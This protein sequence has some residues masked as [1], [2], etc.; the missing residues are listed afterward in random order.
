MVHEEKE[1]TKTVGG[2]QETTT[3]KWSYYKLSPL[4]WMTYQEAL[5]E[6]RLIGSGLRALGVGGE[7]ETFFNI[8]GQTS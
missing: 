2:K 8:Y 7:G 5:E 3:K 6:T 1:I 4:S